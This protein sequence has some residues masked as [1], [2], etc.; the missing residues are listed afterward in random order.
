MQNSSQLCLKFF[1]LPQSILIF[2]LISL[3]NTRHSTHFFL[4]NVTLA[5][6]STRQFASL[7]LSAFPPHLFRSL[8]LASAVG[9][10]PRERVAGPTA[11]N[12]C[13]LRCDASTNFIHLLICKRNLSTA[14]ESITGTPGSIRSGPA[15]RRAGAASR[16][17][18]PAR[19]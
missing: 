13:V 4:F 9:T 12:L 18:S 14:F 15:R 3:P 19:A 11:E 7:A 16:R 1:N 10:A 8:H 5:L 2:F 6:S 17:L